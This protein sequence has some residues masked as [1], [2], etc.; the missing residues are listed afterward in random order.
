MNSIFLLGIPAVLTGLKFL[1]GLTI[2]VLAAIGVR[3]NGSRPMIF[4]GT[5]IALMTVMSTLLTIAI[6]H[7]VGPST[8]VSAS[9]LSEVGGM[10]LI[11]YSIVLARHT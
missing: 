3:R 6:T 5:G 8:A 2:V 1:L 11:L 9:M 7:T 4:L 10:C